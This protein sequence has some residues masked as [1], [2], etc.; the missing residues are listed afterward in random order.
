M[1][2][3]NSKYLRTLTHNHFKNSSQIKPHFYETKN[4]FISCYFNP[5][6]TSCN[7]IDDL[8]T[9]QTIKLLLKL[10]VDSLLEQ[11]SSIT[12]DVPTNSSSTFENNTKADL[13]K[14]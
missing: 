4:L 8:L 2:K 13:V 7:A 14:M 5:L 1:L 9:L 11:L 10:A 6:I 3:P 12:P